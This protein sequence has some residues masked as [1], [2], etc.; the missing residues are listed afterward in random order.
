MY[1][2][3]RLHLIYSGVILILFALLNQSVNSNSA[4][5]EQLDAQQSK[6][7]ELEANNYR[8]SNSLELKDWKVQEQ[9]KHIEKLNKSIQAAFF[10]LDQCKQQDNE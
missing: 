3:T 4:L 10:A 9:D 6:I 1:K 5:K 2:N 7:V 8:L